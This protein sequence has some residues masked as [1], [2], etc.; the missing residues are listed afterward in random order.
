MQ[1]TVLDGHRLMAV[2][3]LG[4]YA[5]TLM[6]L[7]DLGHDQ[8]SL[9]LTELTVDVFFLYTL[10]SRNVLKMEGPLS[11]PPC[12]AKCFSAQSLFPL[13]QLP[14]LFSVAVGTTGRTICHS[15]VWH[16]RVLLY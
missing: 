8:E 1:R 11:K 2:M 16:C 15:D 7:F 4:G 10:V 13:Q 12:H 14:I 6:N 5:A 3:G 9:G